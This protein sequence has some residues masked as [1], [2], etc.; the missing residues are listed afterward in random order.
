M[1]QFSYLIFLTYISFLCTFVT[2]GTC[3]MCGQWIHPNAVFCSTICILLNIV[4]D[5]HDIFI[6]DTFE[7]VLQWMMFFIIQCILYTLDTV[8]RDACGVYRVNETA[9]KRT[10]FDGLPSQFV[11]PENK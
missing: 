4:S 11:Q 3:I 9:C 6:L 7:Y 5:L 2:F 8:L 10:A 1:L